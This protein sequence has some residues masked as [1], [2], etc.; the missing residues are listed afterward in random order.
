M[1]S[2]TLL[3]SSQLL[4]PLLSTT[5]HLLFLTKDL[6]TTVYLG[7]R[8]KGGE[9]VSSEMTEPES[10]QIPCKIPLLFNLFSNQGHLP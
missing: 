6:G 1:S 8:E 9:R 2:P 3:N 10:P 7:P 5:P 4:L